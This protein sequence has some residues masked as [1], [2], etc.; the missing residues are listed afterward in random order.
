MRRFVVFVFVSVVY[1]FPYFKIKGN[2]RVGGQALVQTSVK[3]HVFEPFRHPLSEESHAATPFRTNGRATQ[4]RG[5]Q[6]AIGHPD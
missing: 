4:S 2:V 3:I 5:K 1:V 6:L